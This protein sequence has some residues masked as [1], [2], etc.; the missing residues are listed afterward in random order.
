MYKVILYYLILILLTALFLSLTGVLSYNPLALIF[1][2]ALISI[3][4]LITNTIFAWAF[5]APPNS[6]SV[7]ITALI[8]ALIITPLSS[9]TDFAF[10]GLA[11]WA[12]ILAMASKYILAI[13]KKHIFNPAAIALVLTAV[14]LNQNASWWVG[15][16][17]L[18][19]V[20]LI[21]GILVARKILRFDLIISFW[22]IKI[23]GF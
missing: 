15:S 9:P 19:P 17:V 11:I 12:S 4:C 18:M 14:Y 8:L 5:R 1:S 2:T 20:V 16:K 22:F 6:E 21:G 7:Y 23:C 13:G 10:F 3:T